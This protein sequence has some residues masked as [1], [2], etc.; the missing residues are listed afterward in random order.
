MEGWI[1]SEYLIRVPPAVERDDLLLA[2]A[3]LADGADLAVGPRLQP[4]VQARP[5]E[6]VA[7][8]RDHRVAR[9]VQADV[10]LEHRLVLLVVLLLLQ[11]DSMKGGL[12]NIPFKFGGISLP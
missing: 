1:K 12:Y 2:D 7:A 5:A 4:L 11:S 8:H 3:R 6:E 9:H 10:A